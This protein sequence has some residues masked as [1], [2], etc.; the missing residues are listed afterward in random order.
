MMNSSSKY[1]VDKPDFSEYRRTSFQKS[2][3]V[4][5]FIPISKRKDVE[6]NVSGES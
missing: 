2:S 4:S 3:N 1:S 6:L 5:P